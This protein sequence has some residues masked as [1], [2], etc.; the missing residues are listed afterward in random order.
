MALQQA[1][2]FGCQ[3]EI[4]VEPITPP[5]VNDPEVTRLATEIAR[6]LFPDWILDPE[7]RVMGSEDMA[8]FLREVPGVYLFLG[9]SNPEKGLVS[10][11]HTPTFDFDEQ[12]LPAATA[13][14][15]SV[16]TALMN[17]EP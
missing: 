15:A 13:L 12:V 14:V 9:S 10:S 5:L 17:P 4:E 11:H 3:A 2:A 6:E 7:F 1:E 16:A 8:F